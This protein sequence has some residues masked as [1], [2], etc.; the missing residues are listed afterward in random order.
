MHRQE[1]EPAKRIRECGVYW[2]GLAQFDL[3]ELAFCIRD[4]ETSGPQHLCCHFFYCVDEV[5]CISDPLDPCRHHQSLFL[6]MKTILKTHPM[7]RPQGRSHKPAFYCIQFKVPLVVLSRV[8]LTFFCK[9]R[10]DADKGPLTHETFGSTFIKWVTSRLPTS[11]LNLSV[12]LLKHPVGQCVILDGV[13]VLQISAKD[14]LG[15]SI[16]QA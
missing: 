16:A 6:C 11:S 8:M 13:D 2:Q 10:T 15:L 9:Y 14:G 7:A 3:P 12:I 4:R 5:V 1:V